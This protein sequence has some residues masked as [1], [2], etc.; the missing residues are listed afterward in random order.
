MNYTMT[1]EQVS[2]VFNLLT[3]HAL[4]EAYDKYNIYYSEQDFIKIKH[5]SFSYIEK[6]GHAIKGASG[7]AIY[8][9]IIYMSLGENELTGRK[10]ACILL[11]SFFY[12][13]F[14]LKRPNESS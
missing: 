14:E 3:N 11:T 1:K 10:M 13:C 5:K 9:G 6:M 4:K 7:L 2:D 12:I 8:V